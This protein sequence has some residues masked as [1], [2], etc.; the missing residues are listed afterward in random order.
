[1]SGLDIPPFQWGQA[2]IKVLKKTIAF[3]KSYQKNPI[4]N[5]NLCTNKHFFKV[6]FIVPI[7][8]DWPAIG[9]LV[10][11]LAYHWSI[12]LYDIIFFRYYKQLHVFLL[13]NKIND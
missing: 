10:C 7:K 8:N 5:I 1:M 9:N 11:V 2:Q 13:D 12:V 6:F 3:R 4:L